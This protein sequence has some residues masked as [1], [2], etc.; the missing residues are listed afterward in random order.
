[1]IRVN[2]YHDNIVYVLGNMG[3]KQYVRISCKYVHVL[4]SPLFKLEIPI[5]S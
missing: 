2:N 1:M 3:I 4:L 5:L